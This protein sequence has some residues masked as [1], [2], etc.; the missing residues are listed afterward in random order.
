MKTLLKKIFICLTNIIKYAAADRMLC[1]WIFFLLSSSILGGILLPAYL[2]SFS[3]EHVNPQFFDDLDQLKYQ[4]CKCNNCGSSILTSSHD[5]LSTKTNFSQENVVEPI[6]NNKLQDIKKRRLYIE[7]C[8]KS[9]NGVA[10]ILL[11]LSL[12]FVIT[13]AYRSV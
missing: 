2:A 8:V 4:S 3:F 13:A 11:Y 10:S 1:V 12:T 9:Y 6:I 7:S 5:V